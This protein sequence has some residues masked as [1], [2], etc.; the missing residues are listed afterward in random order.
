MLR[1]TIDIDECIG[2]DPVFLQRVV[3]GP[4]EVKIE[5]QKGWLRT[6]VLLWS[7]LKGIA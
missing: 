7:G 3:R 2:Q 5:P 6:L 1:I 4:H